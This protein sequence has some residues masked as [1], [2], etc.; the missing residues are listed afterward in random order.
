VAGEA[1]IPDAGIPDAGIPDAGIPDAGDIVWIGFDP[2]A[3][4]KHA[5][6]LSPM[7]YNGRVGRL[8]CVPVTMTIKGYPFEVA[9]SG[10]PPRVALADQA[11]SFDWRKRGAVRKGRVTAAQLASIRGKLKAL[12]AG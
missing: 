12:V 5:V 4:H 3:G 1:C 7:A 10:E 9:L 11:K 8:V 6:V 2:Q